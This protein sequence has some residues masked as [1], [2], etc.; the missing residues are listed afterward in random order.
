MKPKPSVLGRLIEKALSV[1]SPSFGF[2]VGLGFRLW[3]PLMLFKL[4]G[5]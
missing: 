5:H 4:V 3:A 2:R 1:S